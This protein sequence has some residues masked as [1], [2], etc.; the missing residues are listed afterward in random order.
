ML[1]RSLTS[2]FLGLTQ[3][4]SFPRELVDRGE[5][6]WMFLPSPLNAVRIANTKIAKYAL[7][8]KLRLRWWYSSVSCL[9]EAP[10]C[11]DAYDREKTCLGVA[12]AVRKI[13][14]IVTVPW[15]PISLA[16]TH[17]VQELVGTR[18]SSTVNL[19]ESNPTRALVDDF[20]ILPRDISP[21]TNGVDKTGIQLNARTTLTNLRLLTIDCDSQQF[22]FLLHLFCDYTK[23]YFSFHDDCLGPVISLGLCL[24]QLPSHFLIYILTIRACHYLDISPIL[25][26]HT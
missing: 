22:T 26:S 5:A 1:L 18:T 15:L 12:Q 6:N 3:F 23:D 25:R 10:R 17:T 14:L 4:L 21:Q 16:I 8:H 11:K 24:W 19:I 13:S 20:A 7:N 2:A 9:S